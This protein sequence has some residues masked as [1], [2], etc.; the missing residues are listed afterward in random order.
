[1]VMAAQQE[2]THRFCRTGS[3]T[4]THTKTVHFWSSTEYGG[5]VK[6]LMRACCARHLAAAHKYQIPQSR[7]RKAH[8]RVR[9]LFLRV[10]QY[11]LYPFTIFWRLYRDKPDVAV[12]CTNTFYAPLVASWVHPRVIYLMYDL[13]PEALVHSGKIRSGGWLSRAIHRITQTSLDRCAGVVFLGERLKGYVEANYA[14]STPS[15]V[16]PVGADA[17]L[18]SDVDLKERT[19]SILYCGNFGH[20][21]EVTTLTSV[22]E[23]LG[24]RSVS[25][26]VGKLRW[27]FHCSGPRVPEIESAAAKGRQDGL[28]I[29]MGPGLDEDE[30]VKALQQAPIGL[31]T[32]VPGS[33]QVV[34][35]S[36]TYSA[37]CAGQAIL[38]IAPEASDLVDL[39]KK[40]NCG[41]WVEPG[42]VAGLIW[43]L[44]EMATNPD[45]LM[46]RRRNARE[47]GMNYYSTEKLATQWMDVFKQVR[48]DDGNP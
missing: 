39:I 9:R 7:Y 36:K 26:P 18:F 32:M 21:H 28:V 16:I 4:K 37:L 12:V 19:L 38:A 27:I 42:D 2:S 48:A 6:G 3:L 30:W 17:T 11:L 47:A 41:W 1:M 20:M 8:G 34:M 35:P 5:L 24:R 13:F 43:V 46:R 45:E 23:R 31:V 15:R 10:E 14:L 29:E 40:H 22:W 44:E 25:E 33:E